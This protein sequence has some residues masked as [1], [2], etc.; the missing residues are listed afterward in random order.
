[1]KKIKMVTEHGIEINI[2]IDFRINEEKEESHYE[3]KYSLKDK[4]NHII[5]DR[6]IA[7]DKN[8]LDFMIGLMID[9]YG[10]LK[11]I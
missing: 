3:V 6:F 2:E 10:S 11:E 9:S 8:D 4:N 7:G 5:D 1:M